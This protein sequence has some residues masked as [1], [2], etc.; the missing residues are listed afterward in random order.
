MFR[1]A[2]RSNFGACQGTRRVAN[3]TSGPRV[4]I[5]FLVGRSTLFVHGTPVPAASTYGDFKIEEKDHLQYWD[6][7]LRA[8]SVPA[9]EYDEI[10][11]GRCVFDKRTQ[12]FTLLLDR[13][14]LQRKDLVARIVEHLQLPSPGWV[15][16][17]DSHYRCP[18][19]LRGKQ[20]FSEL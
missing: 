17:D 13:C 14:I 9:I 2:S 6:D 10:P 4:G 20:K 3:E 18:H 5:V 11:R 12:K 19:C 1:K 8:G 7:L 16:S 15:L